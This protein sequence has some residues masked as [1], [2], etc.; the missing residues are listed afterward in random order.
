[1]IDQN[2]KERPIIRM[3]FNKRALALQGIKEISVIANG[4]CDAL[5]G[6]AADLRP[7]YQIEPVSIWIEDS[8]DPIGNL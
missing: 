1:M 7:I 6:Q 3:M 4:K 2:N 8:R 5:Q